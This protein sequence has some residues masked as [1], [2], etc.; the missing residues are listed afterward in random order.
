MCMN[1]YKG[2]VT[3]RQLR[4]KLA[5]WRGLSWAMTSEAGN[6]DELGC[7]RGVRPAQGVRLR[8]RVQ[9]IHKQAKT[10]ACPPA[11]HFVC[12]GGARATAGCVEGTRGGQ[13]CPCH[14]C[15]APPACPRRSPAMPA[16]SRV[17][18]QVQLSPV[19]QGCLSRARSC[20]CPRC[21][22]SHRVWG[23]FLGEKISQI[24]GIPG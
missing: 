7:C 21:R 19:A 6:P 8:C 5:S 9:F 2:C 13:L 23:L 14:H 20:V 4:R 22:C 10:K 3:G 12:H 15:G 17:Q 1:N 24:G 11:P 16:L 18:K